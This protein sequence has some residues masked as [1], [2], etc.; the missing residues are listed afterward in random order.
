M[1]SPRYSLLDDEGNQSLYRAGALGPV[2]LG[3]TNFGFNDGDAGKLLTYPYGAPEI[4]D[5]DLVMINSDT[6]M[7]SVSNNVGAYTLLETRVGNQ[8]AYF[9]EYVAVGG[10]TDQFTIDTAGNHPCGVIVARFRNLTAQDVDVSVIGVGAGEAS[11]ALSTGV[12]P[13]AQQLCVA[14]CPLHSVGGTPANTPVWDNG[15]T[16]LA[17]SGFGTGAT[18]VVGFAAYKTGVGTPAESPTVTWT[19]AA[20]DRYMFLCTWT[21]PLS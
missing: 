18:G 4:G 21:T 12:L 20:Q 9:Y 13:T 7:D 6:I 2:L 10:E 17:T 5:R 19:S 16:A 1:T 11:P 15:Y 8:G 3:A 14:F